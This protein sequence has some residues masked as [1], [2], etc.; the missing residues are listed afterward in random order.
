MRDGEV[1]ITSLA[2]MEDALLVRYKVC[3]DAV[4]CLNI[5]K[6]AEHFHSMEYKSRKELDGNK[7]AAL[8]GCV[9]FGK[10]HTDI[11]QIKQRGYITVARLGRMN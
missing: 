2:M 3:A 1:N 11:E 5:Q 6:I 8:N 7:S 10:V 9:K 4:E